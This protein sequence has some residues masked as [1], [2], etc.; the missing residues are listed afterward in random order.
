MI[1]VVVYG[2]PGCHLCDEAQ[3][4]LRRFQADFVF[5]IAKVD[6]ESDPKLFD[7]MKHDIPVIEVDG[8]RLWKYRVPPKAFRKVM[9]E[10][11]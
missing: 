8:K 9:E 3:E 4:E 10:K 6:I 11:A 5:E 7:E 1:R 2:K